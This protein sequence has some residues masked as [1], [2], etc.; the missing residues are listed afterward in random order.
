MRSIREVCSRDYSQEQIQAWW[1]FRAIAA[2]QSNL[3][4]A[5]VPG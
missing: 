4:A 2:S 1:V 3:I 5:S